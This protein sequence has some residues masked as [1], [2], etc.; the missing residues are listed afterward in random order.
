MLIKKML[1]L[2][3]NII[4]MLKVIRSIYDESDSF[5]LYYLL[6]VRTTLKIDFELNMSKGSAT[7]QV[8]SNNTIRLLVQCIA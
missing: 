2:I 1:F 8:L 4:M 7:L 3:I 6:T 5:S